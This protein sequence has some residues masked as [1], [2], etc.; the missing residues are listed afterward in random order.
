MADKTVSLPE[1]D[2]LSTVVA[3][4]GEEMYRAL[5]EDADNRFENLEA[6]KRD[7]TEISDQGAREVI[8]GTVWEEAVASPS[9][10]H[11]E[12]ELL[13]WLASTWAITV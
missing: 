13:A 2:V 12:S 4:V 6:L 5:L 9:V 8:Y 11:Q 10:N 7:L 1:Q 3:A